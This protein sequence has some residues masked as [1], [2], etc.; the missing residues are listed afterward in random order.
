MRELH[1]LKE[2][3][4]YRDGLLIA[5]A[6]VYAAGYVVW[7]INAWRN[8]LGLLPA[9]DFQYLLAGS[10]PL[11]IALV[12]YIA[13][14]VLRRAFRGARDRIALHR[15][16]SSW[17]RK[18]FNLVIGAMVVVFYLS[19]VVEDGREGIPR[20]SLV[21]L[22][23]G[24]AAVL[25]SA[26]LPEGTAEAEQPS[27]PAAQPQQPPLPTFVDLFTTDWAAY[28]S[29]ASGFIATLLSFLLPL[30]TGVA[31]VGY[32]ALAV[33]PRLPQEFGGVK[34][35]C[36]RLDLI[37]EQVSSAT[38]SVLGGGSS[39]PVIRSREVSI[40]YSG[41]DTLLVKLQA[42][43]PGPTYELSKDAVRATKSC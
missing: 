1:A 17:V 34:P 42:P 29:R 28:A 13:V 6:V 11:L 2:F 31:L 38:L 10:V 40:Y 26:F 9:L 23:L 27:E 41:A 36:A 16:A 14:L 20:A 37:S 8:D 43:D 35:R 12:A 5:T 22:T 32:F 19:F 7:S 24:A 15:R 18:G 25:L 39:D 33:Y 21:E 4:A 3:G 30:A